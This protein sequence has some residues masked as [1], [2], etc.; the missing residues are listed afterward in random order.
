MLEPY[1]WTHS[2]HGDTT[3][4]STRFQTLKFWGL[5]TVTIEN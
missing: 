1:V 4:V 3:R 5:L 2:C